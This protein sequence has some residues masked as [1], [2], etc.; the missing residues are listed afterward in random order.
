MGSHPKL[1]L[2]LHAGVAQGVSE[3]PPIPS[4]ASKARKH[5]RPVSAQ[6]FTTRAHEPI[7]TPQPT[8]SSFI[9]LNASTP[10]LI[11][12]VSTPFNV[13]GFAPSP[14][15]AGAGAAGVGNTV[16]NSAGFAPMEITPPGSATSAQSAFF[17]PSPLPASATVRMQAC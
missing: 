12:G 17:A 9:N 14:I 2:A 4:S 16:P 11:P 7:T 1:A 13:Q 6:L 5:A 10:S 3:Q 15:P 8:H